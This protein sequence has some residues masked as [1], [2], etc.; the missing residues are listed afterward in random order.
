MLC[1]RVNWPHCDTEEAPFACVFMCVC[2]PPEQWQALCAAKLRVYRSRVGALVPKRLL[3]VGA[4]GQLQDCVL[5]GDTRYPQRG[6]HGSKVRC[7]TTA[8][9]GLGGGPPHSRSKEEGS[10][11]DEGL[12]RKARRRSRRRFGQW[13]SGTEQRQRALT[14]ETVFSVQQV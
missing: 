3:A 1:A 10:R 5:R 2:E 14:V 13:A 7:S 11:S 12:G 4:E 6:L 9:P 8:S